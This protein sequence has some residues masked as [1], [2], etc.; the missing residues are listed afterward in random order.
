MRVSKDPGDYQYA[1][2]RERTRRAAQ[3]I[4]A[5]VRVLIVAGAVLQILQALHVI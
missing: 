2:P 1:P 4:S 5:S 3:L